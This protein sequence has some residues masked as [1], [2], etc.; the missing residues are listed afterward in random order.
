MTTAQTE[1]AAPVVDGRWLRPREAGAAEPRW[2][3]PEGLQVGLPPLPGPRGLLRIY[4]PHVDHAAPRMLN[5]IA[6]EPL[7][8]G[9]TVRGYSELETS[10][11]DGRPGK[12][13]WTAD[14]DG[15]VPRPLD[16]PARGTVETVAGVEQLRVLVRVERFDNG[17]EVDVLVAFRADRPHEVT[18]SSFTR[19]ASAPLASCILTATMGNYARLRRLELAERTVSPAQ[20]WPGFTGPEF[21]PHARFGLAEVGRTPGGDA[22]VAATPDE[23]EHEAGGYADGTAEHWHYTGRRARQTWRVPEPDPRLEVLVNARA[24][25]WASTSPIPGGPAFENVEVMEPF[26]PGKEQVFGVEPLDS[27]SSTRR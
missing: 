18:L 12:I 22:L 19:P 17:A 20:L 25:Y 23:T 6:V 10:R 24:T 2:G 8:V 21:A 11:V 14:E 13:L 7:P 15:A 3:H 9:V 5:F 16:E 4:A 26:R 1:L 27:A